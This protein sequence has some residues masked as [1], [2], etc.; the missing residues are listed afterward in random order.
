VF[1]F[2]LNLRLSTVTCGKSLIFR[3][4]ALIWY[5]F[6]SGPLLGDKEKLYTGFQASANRGPVFVW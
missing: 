2:R 4:L 5:G 1:A 3:L 6:F